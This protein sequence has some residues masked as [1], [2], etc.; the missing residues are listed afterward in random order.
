MIRCLVITL[1]CLVGVQSTAIA[2]ASESSLPVIGPSELPLQVLLQVIGSDDATLDSSPLDDDSDG[3]NN[4]VDQCPNTPAGSTVDSLGCA[5]SEKDG[6]NDGVFNDADQCPNT[7][8]GSAV[9]S[10]GCAE[11]EKDGD[12]DGVFNDADQCPNTPAGATVDANGCADSQKDDDYD[13]VSN[14]ADQCP[15]TESG[16]EVDS[17]G[18]AEAGA[19]VERVYTESIDAL[20]V[21]GGCTSSGC[22]GRLSAPGG[23]VLRNNSTSSNYASL[24]A[25]INNGRGTLLLNKIAGIGHGGGQRYS[26]SSSQYAAIEAWVRSVEAQ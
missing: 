5:E 23:L 19:S 16:V 7:P 24:V 2:T 15:D 20:I 21:A 1:L 3:V 14:D 6:D 13:G 22:H 8:V 17:S 25:Y 12:N 9:D 26:S 10:V 11:S 18:C 4:D